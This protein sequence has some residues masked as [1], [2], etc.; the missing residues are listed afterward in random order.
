MEHETPA[1]KSAEKIKVVKGDLTKMDVQAIVNPANSSGVMGGGVAYYIKRAG[2]EIIEQEAR[3][4]APIQVGEAVL[5]PAGKLKARHVIH[6]PTMKY[7]AMRIP[8]ANARV[9]TR[10]ALDLA[11]KNGIKRVAFPGMG[12]GV[13]GVSYKEA[14]SVMV[15]EIRKKLDRFDVVYLVGIDNDF[16]A[17]FEKIRNNSQ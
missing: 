14:A 17:S 2:G 1:G 8:A 7:P 12:T 10:A 13:G 16:V 5:T 3:R 15:D 9:A 6:A 11:I 4:Q